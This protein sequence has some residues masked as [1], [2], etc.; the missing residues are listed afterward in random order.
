MLYMHKQGTSPA[1]YYDRFSIR[2]RNPS[3]I[4]V[5]EDDD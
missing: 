1:E 4:Y 3:A 2:N 5:I